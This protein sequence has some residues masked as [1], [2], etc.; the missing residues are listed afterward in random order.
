MTINAHPNND[1][2]RSWL[3]KILHYHISSDISLKTN[4][5]HFIIHHKANA[6]TISIPF[7]LPLWNYDGSSPLP[8]ATYTSNIKISGTT[9]KTLNAPAIKNNIEQIFVKNEKDNNHIFT[10]D[11]FALTWFH[12]CRIEELHTTARD[13]HNRFSAKHSDAYKNN[14]LMRPIVDEWFAVLKHHILQIWP[15]IILNKHTYTADVSHD[16]DRPLYY[17]FISPRLFLSNWKYH[18]LK[19]KTLKTFFIP[20]I[21]YLTQNIK[22]YTHDPFNQFNWLMDQ[23]DSH[24]LKSTFY[25]FGGGSHPK[26]DAKYTISTPSI[27]KLIRTIHQRGHIIGLHGSYESGNDSQTICQEKSAIEKTLSALK[28]NKTITKHR[29]HYLRWQNKSWGILNHLNIKTDASLGYADHAGFRC[30][31]AHTYPAFD[32]QNN[33]I[34]N[35]NILPLIAMECSILDNAYMKI[36]FE[37]AFE[38]FKELIDTC[39]TVNGTFTLLWH[40]SYFEKENYKDLYKKILHEASY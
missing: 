14:Y 2:L 23:S 26:I 28:I 5:T 38:V 17:G 37:N 16:V 39:K 25:F 36:P 24:N 8:H 29:F 9:S 10:Y 11:L 30:G 33:Q 21:T 18:F 32:A 3:Q 15:D 27:K 6:Q 20:P 34:L 7:N 4:N 22:L 12:L 1:S 19:N 31:T 40:N 35:Y 13:Q